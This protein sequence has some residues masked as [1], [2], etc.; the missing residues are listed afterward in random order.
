MSS[1]MKSLIYIVDKDLF[2][3]WCAHNRMLGHYS[4]VNGY[5]SEME[6]R[7]E[8]PKNCLNM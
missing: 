1:V 4:S 8:V 6:I 2:G 3:K 7:G 5:W